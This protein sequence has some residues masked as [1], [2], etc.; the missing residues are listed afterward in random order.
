MRLSRS[1]SCWLTTRQSSQPA[2]RPA[3]HLNVN[4]PRKIMLQFCVMPKQAQKQEVPMHN[5]CRKQKPPCL[6]CRVCSPNNSA[7]EV[8]VLSLEDHCDRNL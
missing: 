4:L 8:V 6:A 3:H 7:H 2:R 1:G 5:P